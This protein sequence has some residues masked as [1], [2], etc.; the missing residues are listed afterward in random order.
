MHTLNAQNQYLYTK[1]HPESRI[2]KL[3]DLPNQKIRVQDKKG[4]TNM[5]NKREK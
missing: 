3:R 5:S 1:T 4:D 2:R